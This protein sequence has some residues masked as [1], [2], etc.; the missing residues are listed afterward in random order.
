MYGRCRVG[1]AARKPPPSDL[2]DWPQMKEKSRI[3]S[4]VEACQQT[5]NQSKDRRRGEVDLTGREEF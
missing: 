2:T 1:L 4:D 3:N 5:Q